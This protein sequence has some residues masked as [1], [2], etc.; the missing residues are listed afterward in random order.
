MD[1]RIAC[2]VTLFN[3][4][5]DIILYDVME[6]SRICSSL[7]RSALLCSALLYFAL[8]RCA[9][10]CCAVDVWAWRYLTLYISKLANLVYRRFLLK[11]KLNFMPSKFWLF[12][13]SGHGTPSHS[14]WNIEFH[15]RA[16]WHCSNT[17]PKERSRSGPVSFSFSCERLG[18]TSLP[19]QLWTA[20]QRAQEW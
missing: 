15:W 8:L 3:G 12:N 2:S 10:L 14:W 11:I 6:D 16:V 20:H 13:F 5:H 4:V 19:I 17:T 9:V 1:I 7:L 18:Y